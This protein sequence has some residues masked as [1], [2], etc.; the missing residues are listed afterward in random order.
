MFLLLASLVITLIMSGCSGVTFTYDPTES[1]T[2]QA[3]LHGTVQPETPIPS[4]T[5][6]GL[7]GDI[8]FAKDG[9]PFFLQTGVARS[10]G[11]DVVEFTYISKANQ[12]VILRFTHD[13][14]L[15]DMPPYKKTFEG[16]TC[17]TQ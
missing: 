7:A 9:R 4:L 10:S 14:L 16:F 1:A 2:I 15:G 8:C 3:R 17:P 6:Y 12:L 5:D 13:S 11:V